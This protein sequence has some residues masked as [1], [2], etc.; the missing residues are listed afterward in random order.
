MRCGR[1]SG[2]VRIRGVG[3]SMK[4]RKTTKAEPNRIR[5]SFRMSISH[6]LRTVCWQ[7][8][9]AEDRTDAQTLH[10]EVF[11]FFGEPDLRIEAA[12]DGGSAVVV[13]VAVRS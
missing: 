4:D 3:R 6:E 12:A 11:Q 7:R 5:S 1:A 2:S 8:S 9:I 10:H 13:N